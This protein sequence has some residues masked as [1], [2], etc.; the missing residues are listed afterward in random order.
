[1]NSFRQLAVRHAQTTFTTMSLP[2]PQHLRVPPAL[3]QVYNRIPAGTL[4][5]WHFSIST[6]SSYREKKRRVPDNVMDAE[7]VPPSFG[8]DGQLPP[9]YGI[10]EGGGVPREKWSR[11]TRKLDRANDGMWAPRRNSNLSRKVAQAHVQAEEAYGLKDFNDYLATV[12]KNRDRLVDER[13]ERKM[14]GTPEDPSEDDDGMFNLGLIKERERELANAITPEDKAKVD[15][16]YQ[17][18]IQNKVT[19]R[20]MAFAGVIFILCAVTLDSINPDTGF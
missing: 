11:A 18:K 19:D 3:S 2:R 13:K 20:V 5:L 4:P 9:G 1:M 16:K 8:P 7:V 10:P 15:E 14:D 6:F 12:Q 17:E